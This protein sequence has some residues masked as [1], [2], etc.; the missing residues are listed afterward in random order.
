MTRGFLFLGR[1]AGVLLFCLGGATCHFAVLSQEQQ[2][3]SAPRKFEYEVASIKPHDPA[4]SSNG[5]FSRFSERSDGLSATN[6]TLLSMIETASGVEQSRVSGIPGWLKS[7]TYDLE[8]R[9]DG[10]TFAVFD[11]LPDAERNAARSQML[12]SLLTDRL[13]L[14]VHRETR[15]LPVYELVVAKNGPKLLPEDLST[16]L[17]QALGAGSDANG[18]TRIDAKAVTLDALARFLSGRLHRM[19]LNKTGLTDRY[20]FTLNYFVDPNVASL[21]VTAVEEGREPAVPPPASLPGATGR[22]LFDAIQEQLGLKLVSAKGPVEIIVID[23]V[24]RPSAN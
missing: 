10:S 4:A 5:V 12:Q 7:D 15:E 22:S 1:A 16:N 8:A 2:V 9:M 18:N 11:A 17:G 6:V 13:K 24:E 3:G 20:Q 14:T 21:P 23:H 19:V